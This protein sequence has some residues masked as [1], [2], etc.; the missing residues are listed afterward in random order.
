MIARRP[1]RSMVNETS[2]TTTL[3]PKRTVRPVDVEQR[4]AHR[5]HRRLTFDLRRSG[6]RITGAAAPAAR[7]SPAWATCRRAQS[8]VG[9]VAQAVAEEVEAER[10][11]HEH[12]AGEDD[13]AGVHGDRRLQLAE[14]ASPR[15][16]RPRRQAEVG[17]ARPRRGSPARRPARAG[18][19][20]SAR[21]WAGGGMRTV[22][23]VDVPDGVRRQDVV[24]GEH[25][26]ALGAQD[27]RE[28]DARADADRDR[29]GEQRA[30]EQPDEDEGEHERRDGDEHVDEVGD[31][32]AEEPRR[33]RAERR[34]AR[35]RRRR[36]SAPRR[37][38]RT[39]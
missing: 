30:L 17:R 36:R 13:R 1:P 16:P 4:I 11:E 34:R 21:C 20:R 10:G 27:A 39:G 8:R 18:R 6:A 29:H 15:R 5:C 3:S 12:H 37:W 31:G 35:C 33:D 19:W 23:H 7:A 14:G 2:S 38:R 9:G 32:L 25:P 22:R 28:D 24:L 26:G